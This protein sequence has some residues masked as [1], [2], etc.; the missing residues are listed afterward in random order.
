MGIGTIYHIAAAVF[1]V[2]TG[3]YVGAI[4]QGCAAVQGDDSAVSVPSVAV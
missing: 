3:N 2:V 1:D 4:E